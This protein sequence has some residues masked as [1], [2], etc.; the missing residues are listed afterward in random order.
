MGVVADIE[1]KLARQRCLQEADADPELRTST[2][3]HVVWAPPRWLGRAKRVLAGL[4]E[5]HPAR[6]IFLVPVPGRRSGVEADAVVRDFA[7]GDGREVLSEV[8]ELRIRGEAA[9]HPASIV[10]PLLI[11]DLPAFCRWRGQPQWGGQSLAELVDVCDRL[12][13][14]S[15]EWQRPPAAYGNLAGLFERV[16]VS[17]LAWRRTLPWR[18]ALAARWPGI[19]SIERLGVE[20]P[21]ADALLLAGWLRSRLHRDVAL[22]R[23]AAPSVAAVRVDGDPVAAPA[24]ATALTG[25]DLL[26][27]EL[28]T[29]SRDPVY[30]AAVRAAAASA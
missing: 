3:T 11:P 2:M 20:G 4:A 16:A 26:S 23:R 22:T 17:D 25:S 8:I 13:F 6:T 9:R 21:R 18:A 5:R 7:I 12:V 28:D 15:S 1:R 19:R 27:A 30:E 24:R 29:L 10:L 14:D